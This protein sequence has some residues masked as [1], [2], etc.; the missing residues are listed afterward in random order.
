MLAATTVAGVLTMAGPA[1]ADVAVE[2]PSA[3]Q[4]SGQNI[5]FKVTNTG[6]SAMTKVK[7]VLPADNPVAEVFPLSNEDW[8]PLIT[9]LA[10]KTPLTSIHN[11]TPVTETAGAVTWIA[12]R[13]KALA[14]GKTADLAVALGPLP[15]T[16][17]MS[18][19]LQPTY[20][21]GKPG[22]VLPPV[23]LSL[24]P[25]QPGQATGHGG[26]GGTTGQQGDQATDDATFEAL[27]AAADDGPGFW[28]YAGWTIAGLC[29]A[30]MAVL[31][32]RRKRTA[33]AEATGD[34]AAD[35]EPADDK[36]PVTAGAPRV[37]SWS[38]RDGPG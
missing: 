33:P 5:H 31:L 22:P 29:L 10:L 12:V 30:A 37:T 25:A 20:A 23:S 17:T 2:P 11:G 1:M 14:P 35:D 18:F 34:D 7:L 3:P 8:A 13:G 15:T 16:S 19:T 28:T 4:G 32:L 26:H 9:P 24:T 38:Y 21:D 27:L 6:K 36:E